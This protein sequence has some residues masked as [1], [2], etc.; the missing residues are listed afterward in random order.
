MQSKGAKD[1]TALK[2]ALGASAISHPADTMAAPF[3]LMRKNRFF[4]AELVEQK[5]TQL[6]RGRCGV[7]C[8]LAATLGAVK[9][10]PAT[11]K[12][13]LEMLGV[14][15]YDKGLSRAIGAQ[16]FESAAGF[17]S[18]PEL[19]SGPVEKIGRMVG[20]GAFRTANAITAASEHAD[21]EVAA[22]LGGLSKALVMHGDIDGAIAAA[23]EWLGVSASAKARSRALDA[24]CS[25]LKRHGNVATTLDLSR[26]AHGHWRAANLAG[27]GVVVRMSKALCDVIPSARDDTPHLWV[28]RQLQL[29]RVV[30]DGQSRIEGKVLELLLGREGI[31]TLREFKLNGCPGV[32]GTIPESIASSAQLQVFD[33]CGC[34][35][36]GSFH[37]AHS[38]L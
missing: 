18:L 37:I 32:I 14:K 35:L 38:I 1:A 22:T 36:S 6:W 8:L 30:L 31:P 9:E 12:D 20:T 24:W 15:Y 21:Q 10:R 29:Q 26:N 28:R 27:A 25:L 19:R 17:S 11:A 23:A 5:K 7:S 3:V 34:S 13:S 2:S 33:V 4:G 16:R